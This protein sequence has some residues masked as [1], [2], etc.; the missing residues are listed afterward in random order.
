MNLPAIITEYRQL[1][2]E[3]AAKTDYTVIKALVAGLAPR[4]TPQ[5]PASL[6]TR[7]RKP[8]KARVADKT[9]P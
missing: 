6:A 7:S 5:A 4:R 2:P 1:H 9:R 3:L 8:A